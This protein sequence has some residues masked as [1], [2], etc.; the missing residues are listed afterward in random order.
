MSPDCI[1]KDFVVDEILSS[2]F[3]SDLVRNKTTNLISRF[4][5][6]P[7]P[8]T[9]QNDG[10]SLQSQDTSKTRHNK[11]AAQTTN[12]HNESSV[13]SF[14]DLTT[15]L[16]DTSTQG[17]VELSSDTFIDHSHQSQAASLSSTTPPPFEHNETLLNDSILEASK[18][19]IFY[20]N[21]GEVFPSK[22]QDS[23]PQRSGNVNC[24]TRNIKAHRFEDEHLS[25]D[26]RK[27]SSS[28]GLFASHSQE[29]R[30]ECLTTHSLEKQNTVVGHT[31]TSPKINSKLFSL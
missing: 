2:L 22:S 8:T 6:P 5:Y 27:V 16:L 3:H 18:D 13:R 23:F 30:S 19:Q 14:Y 15:S 24:G 12:L 10:G 4:A 20:R 7:I 31:V 17:M 9:Q 21:E 11:S 26:Q 29:A 1:D 28:S 25:G